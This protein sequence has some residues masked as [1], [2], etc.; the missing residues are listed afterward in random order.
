MKTKNDKGHPIWDDVIGEMKALAESVRTG[1][2][3]AVKR[4]YR[5][6]RLD[7]PKLPKPAGPISPKQVKGLRV[8]VGVSQPVFAALLGVS[9]QTVKAWEQ[10]TKHPTSSARRLLSEI[11]I[12][13]AYWI[14]R[15]ASLCQS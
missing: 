2:I 8:K 12:D 5:I 9:P 11:I 4:K 7:V 1:G 14:R 10:G 15:M 13:P 6:T 3:S